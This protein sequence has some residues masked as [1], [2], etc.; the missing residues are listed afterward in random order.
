M[1]SVEHYT[2]D[3]RQRLLDVAMLSIRSGLECG[4]QYVPEEVQAS[5]SLQRERACFVTLKLAGKLRGCVGNMHAK[6]R[7]VEAV[8]KN[9]YRAAFEDTRFEPVSEQE[10]ADLTIDISVLTP[11]KSIEVA[12]NQ[13]L[14]GALRPGI[15]GLLFEAG[16]YRATFLPSV[17]E[18]LPSAE[19]FVSHLKQKAGLARDYWSD[20]VNCWVYQ[21]IKIE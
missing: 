1:P 14:I 4:Q 20:D 3:D 8:A 7:L 13:E 15:D 12:S 18:Q 21:A 6:S 10:V 2:E 11:L 5:M 17:W 19:Q 16:A 9:A